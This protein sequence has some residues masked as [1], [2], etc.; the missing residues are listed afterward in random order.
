[1]G[2]QL[3]GVQKK[4]DGCV[5]QRQTYRHKTMNISSLINTFPLLESRPLPLPPPCSSH[6]LKI[7]RSRWCRG[8][9][10]YFFSLERDLC[11]GSGCQICSV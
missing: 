5:A 4:N 9:W 2:L 7:V 3:K 6:H 8:N 11:I 10:Q 1:M